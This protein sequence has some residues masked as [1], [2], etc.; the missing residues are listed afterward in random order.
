MSRRVVQSVGND[1]RQTALTCENEQR[2]L[3]QNGQQLD[4]TTVNHFTANKA[5]SV[6][7][8][9]AAQ[10]EVTIL[11]SVA[12]FVGL[13]AHSCTPSMRHEGEGVVPREDLGHI[14]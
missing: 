3:S 10:S 8:S 11:G 14:T 6:Y 13:A 9:E 5:Q 12:M 7:R 1:S 2:V 4:A